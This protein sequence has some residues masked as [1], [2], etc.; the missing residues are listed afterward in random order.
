MM[1]VAD[2][3][4]TPISIQREIQATLQYRA[5]AQAFREGRPNERNP[6][7]I[8]DNRRYGWF[9]GWFDKKLERW[10]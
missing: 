4:V 3:C 5:G 1:A 9:M 2:N 8:G 6:F 10:N 7:P